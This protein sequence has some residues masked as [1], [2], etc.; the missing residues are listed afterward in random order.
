[1]GD[2]VYVAATE[3]FSPQIG[4]RIEIALNGE[5]MLNFEVK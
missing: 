2:I 5:N 4:E 1:M 3:P